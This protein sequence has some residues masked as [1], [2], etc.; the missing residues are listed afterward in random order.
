M[1]AQHIA[2]K[3]LEGL[4]LSERERAHMIEVMKKNGFADRRKSPRVMVEGGFSVLLTM[5]APGGSTS[6]FR[7]YPWDLSRG[8]LGFFHRSFVYPGTRCNF[9]GLMCGGRPF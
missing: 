2:V 6:Y 5:D 3:Y 1:A 9:A 8:G 7:I 4:R